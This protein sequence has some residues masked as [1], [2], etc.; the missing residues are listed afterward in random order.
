[1]N[2][3]ERFERKPFQRNERRPFVFLRTYARNVIFYYPYRQY[4]NP[5]I[6]PFT[7]P[8]EHIKFNDVS[9][10]L[11]FNI[12][13]KLIFKT[14][15][16]KRRQDLYKAVILRNI[17]LVKFDTV[18]NLFYNIENKSLRDRSVITIVKC[19]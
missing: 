16:V 8:A 6:F 9:S 19:A 2:D 10:T 1:M 12:A 3:T 11:V 13:V 18:L 7:L 17:K 14:E 5:F 15:S 4:T